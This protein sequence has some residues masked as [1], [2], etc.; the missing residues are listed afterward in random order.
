MKSNYHLNILNFL[1]ERGRGTDPKKPRQPADVCTV[2]ISE[3]GE[4]YSGDER[5]SGNNRTVALSPSLFMSEGLLFW[6]KEGCRRT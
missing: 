6:K 5:A 1:I 3:E 2:P 4:S